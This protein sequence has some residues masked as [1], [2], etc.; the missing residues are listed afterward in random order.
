M[1]GWTPGDAPVDP[2]YIRRYFGKLKGFPKTDE[3]IAIVSGGVPVIAPIPQADL[4]SALRYGNDRSAEE[5]LPLMWKKNGEDVSREKCLVIKKSA[6]HEIPNVR[7]LPLEA[8][9]THKVRV[10][11]HLSFYLFNRAKK[12]GLNAETDVN[13]V[14]PSLCAEA[15]PEFLTELVSLRAENPKLRLLMA[16]TDV[17]DAYR[18]VRIDPNQA[19]NFCYT[20]GDLVAIDFRLTFGWTDSPGNFGVMASAAEHS[21]CNTDL[22]NVQLLPE[23]VKMME[24]VEIVDRW[25]VGNSTPVPPDAKI[26]ASKEGKLSSPFHTV[27]YVDDHALIRAQQSDEDK[28]SFSRVGL[29]C[30]GLR[31]TFWAERA[32]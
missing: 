27:I 9:V 21:Q 2:D 5:H 32:G 16:T 14:P 8:V 18:N 20:V 22:S 17:N 30:I 7:V 1:S 10:I 31:T 4:E 3:L 29:A 25:E 11:N 24:H 15:L 23:R 6:A 13:I 12:G 19:H 28:I 26:R